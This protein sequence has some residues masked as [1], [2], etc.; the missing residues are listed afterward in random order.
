VSFTLR[1]RPDCALI[2]TCATPDIS[3][4]TTEKNP[5]MNPFVRERTLKDGTVALYDRLTRGRI[6]AAHA[7]AKGSILADDMGLGVS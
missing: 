4:L 6:Q 7:P 1:V 3:R 5:K 2:V